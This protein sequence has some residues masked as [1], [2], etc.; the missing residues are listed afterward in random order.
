MLRRKAGQ[1]CVVMTDKPGSDVKAI[2]TTA[3]EM[4]TATT[5]NAR[6]T[7]GGTSAWSGSMI[8]DTQGQINT[9]YRPCLYNLCAI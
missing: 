4:H 5:E 8:P 3:P 2:Q 9:L 7:W 6:R 1:P